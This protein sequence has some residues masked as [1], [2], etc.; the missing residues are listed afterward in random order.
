M[1]SSQNTLL[2]F[3]SDLLCTIHGS[4]TYIKINTHVKIFSKDQRM[5]LDVRM[6]IYYT[7]IRDMFWTLTCHHQGGENMNTYTIIQGC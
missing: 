2:N 6:E 5:H 1:S 4:T 3:G 7:V